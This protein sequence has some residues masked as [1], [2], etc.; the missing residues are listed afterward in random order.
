M[1]NGLMGKSGNQPR[2]VF[3]AVGTVAAALY[4]AF[5]IGERA[6]LF[7]NAD[8][9]SVSVYL[10]F[11]VFACGYGFLWKREIISGIILIVW[12]GLQWTL[13][14]WVW[15]DGGLTLILG[16]PIALLGIAVVVFSLVR[17]TPAN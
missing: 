10:L 14:L 3:R 12:Y 6:P 4:V 8:F 15:A 5:L 11:L 16:T 13:V 7:R 9:A 1:Y 2:R 17:K